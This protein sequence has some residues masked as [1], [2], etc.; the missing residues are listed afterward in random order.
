MLAGY[1]ALVVAALFTGAALYINAVEQPARPHLGDNAL[2][3]EW[4][5][6]YKRG[7]AMQAPLVVIGLVSGLVADGWRTMNGLGLVRG[8]PLASR[9]SARP[10][11]TICS[12]RP[13]SCYNIFGETNG[14]AR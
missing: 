6:S 3:T 10:G 5:P 12:P 1:L 11:L 14:D 8:S 2:L 9:D 13:P 7:F 4:K